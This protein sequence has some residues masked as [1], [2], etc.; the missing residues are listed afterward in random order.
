MTFS[1]ASTG[2]PSTWAWN[3]GDG[4]SSTVQFPPAHTY[5]TAGTYTVSLVA[6]NTNGSSAPATKTITVGSVPP[7]PLPS[8]GNPIKTMTF[9]GT[10]LTDPV[11]GAG[12]R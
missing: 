2:G 8:G 7:P 11:T 5:T 1:D 10:S 4:T 3:F 12:L 6:S 9:E